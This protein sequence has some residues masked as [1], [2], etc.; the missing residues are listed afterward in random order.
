MQ[1]CATNS[2][3]NRNCCPKVCVSILIDPCGKE[4]ECRHYHQEEQYVRIKFDSWYCISSD[5]VVL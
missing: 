4:E 5:N 2:M 1:P 3:L